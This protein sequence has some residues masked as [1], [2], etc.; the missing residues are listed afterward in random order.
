MKVLLLLILL[1][2][3]QMC[4]GQG[5]GIIN[6]TRAIDYTKAGLPASYAGV[7]P[8]LTGGPYVDGFA[9]DNP[10]G[11]A[12]NT[13]PIDT[14]YQSSFTV[15]ASSW[16]NSPSTC[17]GVTSGGSGNNPCEIL[18]VTLTSIGGN[19]SAE[20][21]MG[22]FQLVGAATGC[23]PVSGPS[24]T[25]RSDKEIWITASNTTQIAYSLAADPG[26]NNCAVTLLY[27]D[28]RK[29]DALIYQNDPINNVQPP[30]GLTVLGVGN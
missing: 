5:L 15:T 22:G 25:A 20:H 24:Y 2:A 28:V 27:P 29:F 14:V 11:V 4:L 16:S 13:L 19:V 1:L 8:E 10:A 30:H 17:G 18:T 12:H 3:A 26:T 9:Y 23:Y 6:P 7:G 21:I